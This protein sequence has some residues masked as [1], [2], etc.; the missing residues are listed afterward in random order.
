MDI[1]ENVMRS[2]SAVLE[3]RREKTDVLLLPKFKKKRNIFLKRY[4]AL[5]EEIVNLFAFYFKQFDVE[6][7]RRK[8]WYD[9]LTIRTLYSLFAVS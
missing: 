7:K 5:N 6:N 8:W 9:K 1:A 3:Y 2:L 4:F